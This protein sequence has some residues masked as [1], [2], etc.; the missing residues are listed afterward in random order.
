ML[1]SHRYKPSIKIRLITEELGFES[2]EETVRL[3]IQHVNT[4]ML[5][6]KDDGVYLTANSSVGQV[7]EDARSGAFRVV[8]IKGQL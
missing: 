6:E 7:F 2:D 4:T 1:T 3:L 5:A 8:D